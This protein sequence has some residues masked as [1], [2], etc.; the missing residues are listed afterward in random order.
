MTGAYV[1]GTPTCSGG[2]TWGTFGWSFETSPYE[3]NIAHGRYQAYT[4]DCTA[5]YCFN[6]V[7]GAG[8]TD[9]LV[10]WYWDGD[11]YNAAPHNPCSSDNYTPGSMS[12]QPCDQAINAQPAIPPCYVPPG[13]YLY[14]AE[15]VTSGCNGVP[16]THTLT[17][18][19]NTEA[20][21]TFAL[22]YAVPSGNGTLTGPAT[23]VAANGASVPFDVLLTP[24]PVRDRRR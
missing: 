21:G 5:T 3:V 9:A 1:L 23:I 11:G 15:L 24:E 4:D 13:L 16:Q 8:V 22:S 18:Y 17:L 12:A 19:N 7:P 6:V 20:D 2:G 14:P 10:S